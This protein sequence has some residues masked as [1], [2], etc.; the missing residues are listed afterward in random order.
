[1]LNTIFHANKRSAYLSGT[2]LQLTNIL[3]ELN[4]PKKYAS[5]CPDENIRNITFENIELTPAAHVSPDTT[6]ATGK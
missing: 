2:F 1:M 5:A 3:I 4:A 6:G